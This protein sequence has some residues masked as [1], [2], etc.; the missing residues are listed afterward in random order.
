MLG[1]GGG[2]KKENVGPRCKDEQCSSD[3]SRGRQDGSDPSAP[4]LQHIGGGGDRL[5]HLRCL[6]LLVATS[7]S[8][9]QLR[10]SS[11]CR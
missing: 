6:L 2:W 3:R 1:C 8:S 5:Q 9:S 10:R 4:L 11:Q 7:T